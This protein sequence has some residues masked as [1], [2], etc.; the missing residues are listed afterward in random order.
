MKLLKAQS[1]LEVSKMNKRILIQKQQ[2]IQ[3]QEKCP[4][5]PHEREDQL[6]GCSIQVEAYSK[7]PVK[8]KLK[9][10]QMNCPW[11]GC[12][13]YYTLLCIFN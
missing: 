9:G 12:S 8:Y 3:A 10:N 2:E 6:T 4:G 7:M 5:G 1:H 13:L 11:I